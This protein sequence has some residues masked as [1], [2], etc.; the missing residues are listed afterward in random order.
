MVFGFAGLYRGIVQSGILLEGTWKSEEL[1]IKTDGKTAE[2]YRD[3]AAE[4]AVLSIY[5]VKDELIS[6]GEIEYFCELSFSH[7][8]ERVKIT[9][10]NHGGKTALQFTMHNAQCTIKVSPSAMLCPFGRPPKAAISN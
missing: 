2:F 5:S 8:V 4:T 7:R 10:I 9:Y 1:L 3:G 6:R